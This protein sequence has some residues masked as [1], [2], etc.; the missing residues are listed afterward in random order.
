[1]TARAPPST[2]LPARARSSESKLKPGR[3]G[4]CE[5]CAS[6]TPSATSALRLNPFDFVSTRHC[7]ASA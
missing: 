1:M 3:R 4:G 2:A 6:P 7:I 5:P